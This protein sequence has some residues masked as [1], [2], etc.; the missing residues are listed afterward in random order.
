MTSS[1]KKT[2]IINII[3][4]GPAYHFS[5]DKKPDVFWEKSDGTF[6][7]FWKREWPDLLGK[8]VFNE[9]DHLAWEVW[10]PD[11]RAEKIYSKKVDEGFTHRLF[12]ASDRYYKTGTKF[13]KSLFSEKIILELMFR[14]PKS[15]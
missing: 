3:P 8:A 10:Q 15:V 14:T 6:L 12:P 11:Y 5:P 7:G 1:Q 4:H 2:T 13:K 9:T